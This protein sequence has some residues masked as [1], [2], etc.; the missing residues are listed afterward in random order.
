MKTPREGG[1]E[2]GGVAYSNLFGLVWTENILEVFLAKKTLL[3]SDPQ[4]RRV[5]RFTLYIR[6]SKLPSMWTRHQKM[7]A[8]H[9]EKKTAL[10]AHLL[11]E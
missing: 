4:K 2:R 1:G 7:S 8:F 3:K 9:I 10:C 11:K 6:C 5:H